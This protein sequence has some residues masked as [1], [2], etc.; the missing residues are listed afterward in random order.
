MNKDRSE[1]GDYNPFENMP[2]RVRTSNV[3]ITS[4]IG[5]RKETEWKLDNG[6]PVKTINFNPYIYNAEGE[7]IYYQRDHVWDL[8]RKQKLIESMLNE[9]N[10]GTIIIREHSLDSLL[11]KYEAGE[12]ELYLYDVVDGKQRLT[13]L[14]EFLDNKFPLKNGMYFKDFTLPAKRKFQMLPVMALGTLPEKTTDEETINQFMIMYYGGVE[15]DK[16]HME[17]LMQKANWNK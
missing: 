10:C 11:E 2:N 17:K 14:F 1:H 16:D 15:M 7:K 3:A 4:Y 9:I 13:A 12:R 8:D 5:F 6:Y